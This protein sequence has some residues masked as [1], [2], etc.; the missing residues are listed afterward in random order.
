VDGSGTGSYSAAVFDISGVET[1]GSAAKV[2]SPFGALD[3][4]A[5]CIADHTVSNLG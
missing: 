1:S 3:D 2:V 5:F 4:D